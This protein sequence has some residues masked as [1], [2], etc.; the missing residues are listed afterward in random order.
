MNIEKKFEFIIHKLIAYENSLI[1]LD[2]SNQF[3]PDIGIN[4]FSISRNLNA[5]FL[6]LLAGES[7]QDYNPAK[8]YFKKFNKAGTWKDIYN[9]YSDGIQLIINEIKSLYKNDSEFKNNFNNLYKKLNK[10]N[11]ISDEIIYYFRKVFFPEGAFDIKNKE[12]EITKL[13]NKRSIKI[14]KLNPNPIVKPEKE[15]LFTSNI[16]IT[17]PSIYTNIEDL[18]Y[19][20]DFK[21]KLK[22]IR[23]EEQSYWYDHPIQIGTLPHA[24]EIIY[25]LSKLDE[26]LKFEEENNHKDRNSKLNCLLS[27]SV[28]HKGLHKISSEYIRNELKNHS[29][30]QRLN[31]YI[32]TEESTKKLL[33]DVIIPIYKKYYKNNN[34]NLL[35]KIFGVDGKYGKHYSFLKAISAFWNIF[36]SDEIKATFKIDLD[37]VFPQ[38]LLMEQS[39]TSAFGHLKSPLWG[40]QGKDNENNPVSL[41]MIAGALVNEKDISKSIYTPDVKFPE[42]MPVGENFVFQSS[43]PQA[44][45]TESEM[46]TKYNNEYDGE[47]RCIQRIHV[48]G[49]TN[50]I[51]VESL[52]KYRPFTP[53]FIGRAEDQS[54]IM[55]VLFNKKEKRYLRYVHKDGLI[56]RHDKETFIHDAIK[57]AKPGKIIGDYIRILFFSYYASV[58][59]KSVDKI[60][61]EL[62]PFTGC[63]ISKMPVTIVYL[64]FVLKVAE[65]Y[66]SIDTREDGYNFFTNGVDRLH[67]TIQLLTKDKGYLQKTYNSEKDGWNLF[68]DIL[69][70]AEEKISKEDA[71]LLEIQKKAVNII[72]SC[73]LDI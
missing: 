52:R 56:M 11:I 53:T 33:D 10:D 60:K 37:Q 41:G 28:T 40:A 64:R 39:G 44:L 4:D 15:I 67:E 50:G 1:G 6:M 35:Y 54:Y 45:S 20:K 68:Y 12:E 43:L 30:I 23:K 18:N 57:A 29:D 72:Q 21:E 69:D 31:I 65:Y 46:M 16:L 36:M 34:S 7:H 70:T 58:A 3:K 73:K 61:N 24:N 63:F 47:T 51:L 42:G 9:F 26:A 19:E 14:T 62:D 55:S 27:V 66:N 71:F 8:Q 32:F 2:F 5:C 38:N 59:D 22:E 48:T 13:R 17:V 25:G 49:G